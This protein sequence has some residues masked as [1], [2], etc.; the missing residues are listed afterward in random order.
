[1]DFPVG[2]ICLGEFGGVVDHQ[3]VLGI[4]LLRGFGEIE[5][6]GDDSGFVD[7]HDLV[8]GDGVGGIDEGRNSFIGEEGGRGVPLRLLALVQNDLDIDSSLF[9]I[10]QR[11]GDRGRGE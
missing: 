2:R 5:T 6:S 3:Q 9:C 8:V 11:L 4:L 1:M 10:D 7:Q